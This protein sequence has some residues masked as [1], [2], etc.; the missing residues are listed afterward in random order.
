MDYDLICFTYDKYINADTNEEKLNIL[1]NFLT[2]TDDIYTEHFF[3]PKTL[4]D[5]FFMNQYDIQ[6]FMNL[7]SD[8]INQAWNNLIRNYNYTDDNNNNDTDNI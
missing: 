7:Y 4:D 2:I 5:I 6:D 3:G 1:I 8:D